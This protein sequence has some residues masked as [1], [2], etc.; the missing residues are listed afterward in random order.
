MSLSP[1]GWR[2]R[3]R[4]A[5]RAS[6][7]LTQN[8]VEAIARGQVREECLK[9]RLDRFG[10]FALVRGQVSSGDERIEFRVGHANLTPHKFVVAVSR[11]IRR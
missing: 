4:V 3:Q 1:A 11:A 6:A 2:H 5:L 7:V 8:L 9:G 10:V